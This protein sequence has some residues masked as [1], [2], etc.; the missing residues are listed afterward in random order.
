MLTVSTDDRAYLASCFP[1]NNVRYLPSFHKDDDINI[2]PGKGTFALYHGNLGVAENVLA[3]KFLI[4]EV[5]RGL[6]TPLV[7]AGLNPPGKLERM[8]RKVPHVTLIKNPSEDKMNELIRTAQV[9]ILVTFQKTGLK[10]KLLNAL[11]SGRF[12]LVNPEMVAGTELAG[13]CESGSGAAEL[14]KIVTTLMNR[15]FDENMIEKR[16]EAL[17]QFHSNTKNCE[18]LLNLLPLSDS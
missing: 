9:N 7:I 18:I 10:L 13:L 6:A 17:M 3:A 8:I 12:C 14:K 15:S 11:F 5:F 1:G 2:L 4:E 16:K